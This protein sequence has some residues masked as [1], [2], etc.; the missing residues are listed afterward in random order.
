MNL[1]L[2]K[3]NDLETWICK[4]YQAKGIW[5]ASQLDIDMIA[6]MF[7]VFIRYHTEETKAI[8]NDR[9]GLIYILSCYNEYQRREKFF[10]ELG[11]VL[12]HAGDQSVM[13][14]MFIQLQERQAAQFQL[15]AAIPYYMLESYGYIED[16]QSYISS[17]S[18][19]FR[20]PTT[21]VRKRI[22]Q[23]QNRIY[24]EKQE[25]E[26]R[27]RIKNQEPITQEYIRKR[28]KELGRQWQERF[29]TQHGK[30]NSTL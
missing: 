20:L 16:Q 14:G 27:Q 1:S 23:I 12:R 30:S 3:P 10:H 26:Q 28:R 21:L 9:F 25:E 4:K 15:Y 18:N 11:H 29:G 24:R 22:E 8:Y 7:R 17:L 13:H 6:G 2:Y 19:D 5:Y